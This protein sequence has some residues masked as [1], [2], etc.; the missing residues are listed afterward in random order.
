MQAL[1]RRHR[2]LA[3]DLIGFGRNRFFLKKSRLPLDFAGIATLLARWIEEEIKEPVH[4]IGNSMGG[5]IAIHLAAARP[6]LVRSLVL[7]N[8]T[9]VPF[10]VAP[11]EH[12]RSLFVPRGLWSFLLILGRDVFRAGPTSVGLALGRVLRDDARP[13]M[14][15][16]RVPV[17]L[18]WG[19]HDPLV[20]LHYGKE[21]LRHLPNAQLEVIPRAGH[22]PMWE[23]SDRFNDAVTRFLDTV[24]PVEGQERAP[25]VFSWSISGWTGGIAHRQAGRNR[26]IVLIHG[27]GMSSAY[28]VRFA[29]ALFKEGWSPI[30]PDLPGFGESLDAPPHGPREYAELLATWAD[31][32]GIEDA[33]WVGHSLGCNAVAHLA[34]LRPD[35]VTG[36]VFIGPLWRGGMKIG[37]L[38]HLVRDMFREPLRLYGHVL[39]AYWRTG[40]ARWFRTFFRHLG[41]LDQQAPGGMMVV[42]ARDPLV[43]R[44]WI[45]NFVTVSGAHACH[46]THPQATARVVT[47]PR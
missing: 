6:D 34:H 33:V 27:L 44:E 40:F 29:E 24:E 47:G 35:L 22:I 43:D 30:A 31:V 7:V 9:G 3:I 37:L 46:F 32:A 4:L 26:D 25:R 1:A 41:D 39:R 28:Y 13:L 38:F 12:L 5:Q 18:V 10:R 8:S 16:I 23:Q 17:L 11:G 36:A 45:A 15:D 2:V 14:R 21:M 19:E 20:P 42:G